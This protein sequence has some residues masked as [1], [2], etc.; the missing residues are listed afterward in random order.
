M[1]WLERLGV[2]LRGCGHGAIV[3]FIVM[4]L[5]ELLDPAKGITDGIGRS[6]FWLIVVTPITMVGLAIREVLIYR[7]TGVMGGNR[8]A[9]TLTISFGIFFLAMILLITVGTVVENLNA[10]R[11]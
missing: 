9:N 6:Y 8:I 2:V 7:R 1:K 3:A 5:Y 10:R 11:P 4:V